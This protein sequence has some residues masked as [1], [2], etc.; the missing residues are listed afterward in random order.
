MT[1]A[2]PPSRLA[3]I[4]ATL[5]NRFAPDAVT[6]L[7]AA[8]GQRPLRHDPA[9]FDRTGPVRGASVAVVFGPCEPE[10][11]LIRGYAQ[12][13]ATVLVISFAGEIRV[14]NPNVREHGPVTGKWTPRD[15]GQ[16]EPWLIALGENETETPE[17][18]IV[19]KGGKRRGHHD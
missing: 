12:N 6:G 13:G 19:V 3:V 5:G 11:R 18:V 17:P 2:T 10:R 14:A 1:T 7:R 9:D 15:M 4:Y 8:L 16:P